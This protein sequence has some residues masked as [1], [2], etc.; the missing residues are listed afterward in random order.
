M[1]IY[2]YIERERD[3][4]MYVSLYIYIHTHIVICYWRMRSVV[5]GPRRQGG[6]PSRRGGGLWRPINIMIEIVAFDDDYNLQDKGIAPINY[7]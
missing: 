2:I 1:Y 5:G 6:G 4:Y 7:V 3:L